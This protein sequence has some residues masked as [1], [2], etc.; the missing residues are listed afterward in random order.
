MKEN[1]APKWME[2]RYP[3]PVRRVTI[4]WNGKKW[5]V[6][7]QVVVNDM[8]LPAPSQ[9]P[10]GENSRGFWIEAYDND[11]NIYYR[12]VITNPF[13]GMEQFSEKGYMY[14]LDHPPHDLTLEILI[15]GVAEI[16][17]L[18]VVDNTAGKNTHEHHATA[19]TGRT[20]LKL[21]RK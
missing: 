18:H 12:Q 13:L 15:P 3:G 9:L 4:R 1:I 10:D 21:G 8:T 6:E 17:Q 16:S 7:G 19:H 14:R 5:T 20:V 2:V 11:G